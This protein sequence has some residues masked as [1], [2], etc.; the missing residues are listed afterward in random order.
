[1]PMIELYR[2]RLPVV[3]Y[4][5][6]DE[7]GLEDLWMYKY[8]LGHLACLENNTF[9]Y[10]AEDLVIVTHRLRHSMVVGRTIQYSDGCGVED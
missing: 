5:T 6:A 7:N 9:I 4:Y 3:L 2:E 8:L 1:M 10:S